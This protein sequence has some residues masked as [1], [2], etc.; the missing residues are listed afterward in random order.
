MFRSEEIGD[1]AI[2]SPR[3]NNALSLESAQLLAEFKPPVLPAHTGDFLDLTNPYGDS[4][5]MDWNS[6]TGSIG[7]VSENQ[8]PEKKSLAF[9]PDAPRTVSVDETDAPDSPRNWTMA[10]DLTSG[11]DVEY[12]GERIPTGAAGKL[13]EILELAEK[14]RDQPVTLY[15]Q[16]T[17]PLPQIVREDGSI[18]TNRNDQEVATY[19]LE[20]GQITL[21]DR[22]P[23]RGFEHDLVELLKRASERAGDG[24]LGLI[25]QS[26]GYAAKGLGGDS[27]EVSLAELEQAITSGL[28]G[29][30]K[31]SLDLLN[32][33][34][35]L[36]G[37]L[38]VIQAMQGNAEH[39]VAS[40]E[41]ESAVADADGQNMRTTLGALLDNPDL[42]PEEYAAVSIE[43]AS[44]GHNDET[45]NTDLNSTGTY[46]LAH[47][48]VD[49]YPQLEAGINELGEELSELIADPAQRQTLVELMNEIQPF[50]EGGAMLS[51]SFAP[52]NRDLGLF[53]AE[54]EQA[55]S[56]G[57]LKDS[58]GSLSATVGEVRDALSD[59]VPQYHGENFGQYEEMSGLS[60][61]LP[62]YEHIDVTSLLQDASPLRH[63]ISSVNNAKLADF[64]SRENLVRSLTFNLESLS[65]YGDASSLASAIENLRAAE[66]QAQTDIAMANLQSMLV[67]ANSGDLGAAWMNA[68]RSEYDERRDQI[69]AQELE[70]LPPAWSDFIN[71]LRVQ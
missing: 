44:A 50:S 29:S 63:M 35:C 4:E 61:F 16:A 26:H 56:N 7:L 52:A 11:G 15:V 14:T 36:M 66:D 40:A 5:S 71:S 12:N 34:S 51:G 20:D 58:D 27:G 47:V 70:Q 38:N 42:T 57:D 49:Q 2:A 8:A 23:S 22:G 6:D 28:D 9:Q 19:R 33:D 18:R 41:V 13:S 25:I 1:S 59:V 3:V 45:G 48:D 69:F 65:S 17:L 64:N 53:L 54:L 24:N 60:L 31:T 67:D 39:I 30:G 68:N 10:I 55:V 43:L 21:V 62:N 32:F 37:N 46:T